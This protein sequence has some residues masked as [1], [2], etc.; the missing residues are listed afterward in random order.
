ML[1]YQIKK[2]L[3]PAQDSQWK[4]LVRNVLGEGV[5]VQREL[6]FCLARE[7]LRACFMQRGI[8]LEI[9]ELV[10]EKFSAVKGQNSLT[11]SLSHAKDW[12]AAVVA[13]AKEVISVGI[14]IEPKDRVVKPMILERISHPEDFP[15]HPLWL[16]SLKEASFK[17]LM[18]TGK[19]EKPVEFSSLKVTQGNWF[20]KASNTQGEWKVEEEQGL[21]VALAWINI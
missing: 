1:T 17:A 10:L 7:A 13:S 3:M 8:K 21:I 15:L 18:N 11:I 16:W 6:G 2:S 19:F 12:G 14:D 9:P 20:H 4:Q 5:H